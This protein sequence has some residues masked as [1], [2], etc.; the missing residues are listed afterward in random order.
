MKHHVPRK[1]K[2]RAK[3]LKAA[4]DGMVMAR[5]AIISMQGAMQLAMDSSIPI[6]HVGSLADKALRLVQVTTDVAK[7]MAT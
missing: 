6:N 5:T 4:N 2:K 1:K 3:K 7:G